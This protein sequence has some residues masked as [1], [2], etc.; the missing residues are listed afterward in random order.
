MNTFLKT[1]ALV[2]VIAIVLFIVFLQDEELTYVDVLL[3]QQGCTVKEANITDATY[4]CNEG[5]EDHVRI[6]IESTL[7]NDFDA[8]GEEEIF[9]VW[10]ENFGGSGT[11]RYQAIFDGM[12]TIKGKTKIGD[13]V[14]IEQIHFENDFIIMDLTTHDQDDPLC[15]PT[16]KTTKRFEWNGQTGV[17]STVVAEE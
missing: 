13:R 10:G 7:T 3:A 6:T 8:D 16:L 5:L 14:I 17:L 15:C 1:T 11:F 9:I 4:L 2:A 12:D